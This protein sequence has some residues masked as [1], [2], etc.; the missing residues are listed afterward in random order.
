MLNISEP[1]PIESGFFAKPIFNLAFR[2]F[3]LLASLFSIFSLLAWASTLNGLMQ[4]PSTGLSGLIWHTHEMLFAFAATV[5]VG[6]ILTAVQTWTGVSSV[7]GKPLAILIFV[8]LLTRALIWT[9]TELAIYLAITTSFIWWVLVIRHF[10]RIVFSAN[11][12]RNYLFIQVLTAIACLNLTILVADINGY[13]ALALH[14]ARTAVLLFCLL[15]T[16]VGGR[17]IPFFTVRGAGTPPAGS[18]TL[19]EKILLPL[20]TLSA[21]LYAISYL[22]ELSFIIGILLIMVA[23][24]QFIRVS[25]WHSLKTVSVPLLWSL[26]V[27]YLAMPIGLILM[28]ASYF[29]QAVSFSSGLHT[30]T[31]GAIGLMILAMMSRVSLGHT[32]RKLEIKPIVTLSFIAMVLA[33]V[34]RVVMPELGLH[35]MGWTISALLWCFAFVCFLLVYMPILFAPRADLSSHIKAKT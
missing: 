4:L 33:T 26:H 21:A 25:K 10:S 35:M 8:W 34:V 30:V 23:V 17:V 18:I 19:L 14:L 2:S 29:T 24:I 11:N 9:N 5:A 22:A 13:S 32:G 27:S 12:Q 20:M 7:K 28:G 16:L 3:F 1:E 15:M 31:V 6:F